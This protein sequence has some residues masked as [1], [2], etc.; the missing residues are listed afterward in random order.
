MSNQQHTHSA[1]AARAEAG[2]AADAAVQADPSA[3]RSR[4]YWRAALAGAPQGVDLPCQRPRRDRAAAAPQPIERIGLSVDA[5]LRAPLAALAERCGCDLHALLLAAWASLLGRLS[6]QDDVVVGAIDQSAHPL[7]LR[8]DLSGEPD[9][10]R[11]AAQV[12]ARLH[13]A[14]AHGE[15]S[16]QELLQAAHPAGDPAQALFNVALLL[17]HGPAPS[18]DAHDGERLDLALELFDDGARIGGALAYDAGLFDRAGAQRIGG[19]WLRLLAAMAAA[20]ERPLAA[21]PILAADERS[22]L[23]GDGN[24]RDYPR[25]LGVH[26]LFEAQA[27][28]TPAAAALVFGERTLSYADLE[29]RAEALAQALRAAGIGAGDR[30]AI[31]AARSV[32]LLVAILATLKSGAAYVP[33]DTAFPRERLVQIVE[34]SLPAL[35]LVDAEGAE[36]LGR[37]AE[38]AVA[39]LRTLALSA[40]GEAGELQ[41]PAAAAARDAGSDPALA[42]VLFTSGSTGR[43]KGVCVPHRAVV[44]FLQA[45]AAEPG[46]GSD[47]VLCAIT[48]ISFD[49]SVL[50]LLLPLS[51]GACVALADRRTAGDGAALAA[52]VERV[53]A[54]AMQATPATWRLLLDAGWTPPARMRLLC[55][56]EAW[57]MD[58]GERLLAGGARLWNVYGPTETTVWSMLERVVPGQ[59]RI[60]L[61]R[62]I[63]NTRIYLLDAYR[64]PVPA[65]V[66]GELYIGGDGVA[67]GYYGRT[68]L[69]A[70]R[71]LPDPHAQ[72]P[73]ARMYRTGDLARRRADGSLEFL[74]RNDFQVKIRGFR[75]ELGEIEARLS[76]CAGVREAVVLA[77][78]DAP[79]D[80]QLVAYY[81]SDEP[82]AVEAL[83]DALAAS[84]PGYMV[85]AAFVRMPVWPSTPNGKLDR[86]ALPAP[87][88]DA[89]A[90]RDYEPPQGATETALASIW[91]N[92][93]RIERVGRRD[94]F[95]ELGGHSLLAVQVLSRLRQAFAVEL[96]QQAL[97]DAPELAQLAAAVDAAERLESAAAIAPVARAEHMPLSLA[98]QRL[99]LLTQIDAASSAYHLYGALR[100]FG[101]VDRAALGRALRALAL[102]HEALRTRFVLVGERAMQRIDPDP[103]LTLEFA[104][105]RADAAGDER[106]DERERACA[107]AGARL[108]AAAFD[109]SRDLP[110]R[111]QLLHVHDEA[112][113]LQ[114][115]VH[116]IVADGWSMGVMYEDLGRLYAAELDGRPADLPA[117]PVQYADCAVW[118]RD[119]LSGERLD[120][121]VRFWRAAL[122]GAPPLLELPSDRSRP[123]RQDFAGACVPVRIEP[124]FAGQLKA[125]ARRHG[126]TLYMLLLSAWGLALGRLAHQDEV[127]IGSP[128]AGR[129]RVETEPLIGFFVNTLALRVDLRGAPSVAGLLERVR[130]HVLQ[131]QAHQDLPFDQVVEAVNP[132][133][134]PAHT[135]VYQAM[136]ALQNQPATQLRMPGAAVVEIVPE[137]TSVQC[138]LLLDLSEIEGA[139]VGRLDYASALFDPDT[140]A[141]FRDAWLRVLQAMLEEP[142]RSVDELSMIDDA[143]RQQ[144]LHLWN[145]TEREYPRDS[146]VHA[147]FQAQ[148]ARTPQAPALVEGDETLSYAELNR[149]ANRIAHRLIAAGVRP[150]DRVAVCMRRSAAMI[151]GL[152]G[153]LKAGAGYVPIDPGYPQ[154]RRAYLLADC[155]PSA[156]LSEAA[157]READWLAA[158]GVPVLAADGADDS[159]DPVDEHDPA[160]AVSARHLAYVIYTSGSTGEPKGVMVEHRN[161]LRLAVNNT[162]AVLGEGDCVAHCSNPS[163]DA[164]TWEI[165]GALLNGA[166]VLV[167]AADTV[168][169]PPSFNRA[170]LDGG[171]TALW[172]TVGLFNEYQQALAPA[173]AGLRHLL[174]G[175]DALD[176]RKV[177]QALAAPQ[178]PQRIVNGYGPTET[179]TFALT[180]DIVAVEPGARSIPIGRPIANSRAYLLDARLQP[181]PVGVAGELYLGGDGVARGYLNRPQLSAERF[182]ADPFAAAA[183]GE[184]AARMYKTGDLARWRSDGTVEF[185]GRNDFQVK[186]RGF[187]I[188]LGEIEARL[189]GCAGVAEAVVL[190]RADAGQAAKR[191]VAY[192][193]AGEGF[194]VAA[195]RAALASELPEYMLPSAFVR[196]D[197]W[198]LTANGKLDRRALPAPEH[199]AYARS[200]YAPP[201]GDAEQAAAAAWS[202]ALKLERVGRDDN[203]FE[204]GGH[205]LIAVALVQRLR[206]RGWRVDTAHLFAAAS[207]KDFAAGLRRDAADAQ[208]PP[209]RIPA[210]VQR[211][212]PQMLPLAT[213]TQAQIDTVVAAVGGAADIQ[214]IY[215]LAPLQEGILFHRMLAERG[216]LY[217]VAMLM[218]FADRAAVED[219]LAAMQQVVDRHDILRTGFVWH[220]LSAPLQVVRRHAR[221]EH[222]AFEFDPADGPVAEQLAAR[223]EPARFRFDLSRA[224]L[225]RLGYAF[226]PQSRQWLLCV[227]FH[228]L[229]MDHTSMEAVLREAGAILQGRA[230]ELPPPVPFREHI[231]RVGANADAQAQRAFFARMLGDIDQPT[232]PFGLNQSSDDLVRFDEC[233]RLLPAALSAQLR[234]RARELGVSATALLHLGWAMVLARATGQE[235]V[236]FGTVLFGRMNAG[237]GGDRALGLFINTL[238]IRIE[239]GDDG[240]AEAIRRTHQALGELLPHEHAPLA[241]AQRCSALPA[242]TPL[243]TSLFNYTYSFASAEAEAGLRMEPSA[244]AERTNYPL[245]VA[246]DD[247]G[248]DFEIGVQVLP[249]IGA[250]RVFD[251]LHAALAGIV[252]AL[253]Q[254]PATPVAAIEVM[255]AGE[256]RRILEDWN[257]SVRDFPLDTCAHTLFAAQAARSGAATALVFGEQRIGYADLNA[258]ANRIAHC[259]RR[260]G[261]GA[262]DLVALA[263]ERGIDMVA[264]ILGTLKAGAAYVPM[265]TD[266]PAER[267]A[268]MLED[269][270]PK[271]LLAHRSAQLPQPCAAPLALL[272]G[273]EAELAASPDSDPDPQDMHAARPAYV[274]YTSGTTGEPKGV[275][276]THRNLVNFVYWCGDAGLTAPGSSMTQFAPYTFDASAGEIF[277]ALLAGTCLHLLDDATIQ[278]PQKLQEYLSEHRVQFSAL[279]PAYLQQMDPARAPE[280]FRLLTAGSAPTPELVER[281][282]GRGDYLNGYGPTETTILSTATA[283]SADTRT[284]SIGRPVANT[285]VYLLDPRGRP[286]PVGAS[287]E[288]WI[289][290]EGVTPGYLNRPE[291]TAERYRPD[292]F[293]AAAGARMYRTGDLGRWLGDGTIEFLGRNDFQ[294]KIRGFRIEPGEIETRLCGFD[295]VREAVVLARADARGENR[296][297]AYYL[298]PAACDTAALRQHL[299]QALPEYMLPAAFVWMREWPLTGNGK[300]D[301]KAL[302]APDE[303]AFARRAYA[304]PEG[305]RE[306]ALAALWAELL[307]VGEI[308]RHDHFFELGGHSLL[309]MRLVS[310]I[311]DGFG[312]EL[313]LRTLFD[314]PV[315]HEL[316]QRLSDPQQARS[317]AIA[318]RPRDGEP[319]LAPAQQ[320]LWFLSQIEGAS[321]AYHMGGAV[322]LRGPLDPQALAWALQAVVERHE[323]L[324][325]RFVARDGR[326]SLRI[327]PQARIELGL[328]DLRGAADPQAQAQAAWTALFERG[329]DLAAD[330]PLR[331]EL[332]RVGEDEH[333]L[334]LAMHH[335]VSDGWSIGVML[336]ELGELYAARLAG[337]PDPLPPLPVQ[338]AD[339]AAWQRDWLE[340]GNAERLSGYWRDALAGAPSA[341]ELPGDRPRPPLQDFSGDSVPVRLDADLT[342]RLRAL[343]QR[344]GTTLYA[345][346]LASWAAL[347][348]RLSNQDEVVV[349]APMAGRGRG[350]IEPLI[351]FF[352]NTVALRVDLAA[353]ADVA[354]L[355]QQCKRTLVD[356]Q[357]HQDLPFDYVVEAVKPP[358]SAAHTPIFQTMLTLNERVE[359]RLRLPGVEAIPVETESR[360]AQFDLSLDLE[361][362]ERDV[363]GTLGYATALFDRSTVQRYAGYWLRLLQ[364]MAAD[365][366]RPLAQLPLADQAERER[367][368]QYGRGDEVE[369]GSAAYLH[370]RFEAQAAATPDAI[371]LICAGRTIA[372]GELNA[373]AN[374]I[375]HRLIA[376]GVGPDAT[377]AVC[378]DRGIDAIAALLGVLKAGGAYVPIDPQLPAERIGYYARDCAPAAVVAS[379]A[380]APLFDAVA[381]AN[382]VCPDRDALDAQPAHD[383]DP[384]ARGLRSA[385]LAYVI[386]TSGSTGQPKGVLIEHRSILARVEHAIG[387]YRLQPADR[388]LQF[389]ALGF[390]ASLLQIFSALGA[391]ASL[392]VR[393]PEPWSAEQ[394]VAEIAAHGI[395]VADLPPSYL[396]ALLLAGERGALERLRI[397]VIGGEATLCDTLRG[398]TAGFA[399][400][401]EYGPTEASVTATSLTLAAGEPVALAGQY[402]PIGRPVAGT[403]AYV[404]DRERRVAPLGAV[405]ELYIGGVGVARGYLGRDALT[406]E[407]FLADPFDGG[408]DARMYRSGDLVRWLPHGELEYLGRNDFQVKLRGFRIELGE[409]EAQMRAYP[410]VREAVAVAR[411]AADGQRSLV[412]YCLV[413]GELSTAGLRAHLAALLPDYMVPAGLVGLDRW[414][415]TS[416]GKLDRNAL[417]APERLACTREGYAPPQGAVERAI[418]AV[419]AQTLGLERVGRDDRFFD[420]GGHSLLM[421]SMIRR[422]AEQGIA[423]AVQDV[424]RFGSLRAIAARAADATADLGQWLRSRD[425]RHAEATVAGRRALWLAPAGE[426]E[427][428]ALKRV[429]SRMP[430]AALPQRIACADDPDAALAAARLAQAAAAP[431]DSGPLL[432]ELEDGLARGAAVLADAAV[433]ERLAFA[434]IHRE[435]LRWNGRD[436]LHVVPLAGWWSPQ[437]LRRAFARVVREQP[438]LRAAA[439]L[440]SAAFE[441][442]DPDAFAAADA[443]WLDLREVAAGD[444]DAH[445]ARIGERL[446]AAKAASRLSYAAALISHSD[447]E[448]LLALY[449]D[450]LIWD[451]QSFD[452]IEAAMLAA[453]TA[454]PAAAPAGYG[455]FLRAAADA[456][457]ADREP[458]ALD[459]LA[460]PFEPAAL[461]ADLRA[462][463]A[464][465]AGRRGQAQRAIAARFAL[466][467][468]V[469]PAQQAFAAFRRLASRVLGLE[470][471]GAVLTHHGRQL[472]ERSL[473]GE[474]GLFVDK[475]PLRVDA[476]AELDAAMRRVADLHREGLRYIDWQRS[477]DARLAGTLPDFADEVS[478]NY[479]ARIG[480]AWEANAAAV[481]AMLEKIRA[482][483]GIVCEF[484][485]GDDDLQMFFAFKGN[486][487]DEANVKALLSEMSGV[488]LDVGTD[489]PPAHEPQSPAP[490]SAPAAPVQAREAAIVVENLRKRYC[491]ADVVKGI[492]FSVPKG[493]CFGILGPNGAGKTSLLGMIEGIVPISS[494]RIQV[495]G[496]DVASQIRKIQPHFGVQLQYSHY[497]QFLTIRELL[498]FYSELRAAASGKRKVVP[499]PG[500]LER[501][502]LADKLK[503]KVEEL[504]GGQK[505]RLSIALALLDDPQIVFLDEPT[506]A[507]DPHSRRYTWEFI[508]ELKRDRNRTIVLTTHYME[509]AERLCDEIMIMNQGEIVGQGIPSLLIADLNAARQTRIKLAAHAPGEAIARAVCAR[510]PTVWDAF[511]DSL[512]ISSNEVAE[513]MGE[514]MAQAQAY[515][516]AIVDIHLERLSLEDVFLNK[517]GK[518]LK[519]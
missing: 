183:A 329:F 418:A 473:F 324:R 46:L 93:L 270:A 83:R 78:E 293:S 71:F 476:A 474:V 15:L 47:D 424:Y 332:L 158:A 372:Y 417:P 344:Q 191:L 399:I 308:G 494:G 493:S 56:G 510:Y 53:G 442:L 119:W 498:A 316:A 233:A 307:G 263:L 206:R 246:V 103:A 23:L 189:A 75:I 210:G 277:A 451:G 401:N 431:A 145:R 497:F 8:I 116:H 347:L 245:A 97:F 506:A 272:D 217:Q 454:T 269:C 207:L 232:M 151:V 447:G 73:D 495:M 274:I 393:G 349:G 284:I 379:H 373:R 27:R 67:L 387:A 86:R 10:A 154:A 352:V 180:H 426:D 505:Q 65:G 511:T 108:F 483:D 223:Y 255:P 449:G 123:P 289:G 187:R 436:A 239:V 12:R 412:G 90:R 413:D 405:G 360:L 96:G 84:L 452:A 504:S 340:R 338:Y 375:A 371:A 304:A 168:L 392:L 61:G 7:P 444:I 404:L 427:L 322:A 396:P 397:A 193:L 467:A 363:R 311:R 357:A 271:L 186:I 262:G 285:R 237:E 30:V 203:F 400:H 195:V 21:L 35:A 408:A 230:A 491:D 18:A 140:A 199:D 41:G 174:I 70:E 244:G 507:L 318:P 482:S 81:Q 513:A 188:E 117:L 319:A 348:G 211:I 216:D 466:A 328:A 213:L 475:I 132:P 259:L 419:W 443:V 286:V 80:K 226:D 88:G 499:P 403:R 178:R 170:L 184:P 39:Q 161:V 248:E 489:A 367:L 335:I 470:R 457:G 66:A 287:G 48:T 6:N 40:D 369:V 148:A 159:A 317:E 368:L 185:L 407:R 383:P 62:P 517:T 486:D 456:V 212:E 28:R 509:E 196:I 155:A 330:L 64:E 209:N 106:L 445:H 182:L 208:V 37:G 416:A 92:L 362:G 110:L 353:A 275:V 503:F 314:A 258:R 241:L 298:A 518:E 370:Q 464:A 306:R 253:E 472:G 382:V 282:A 57:Q 175:G 104:D 463:A 219:F 337:A 294:V 156:I 3:Q 361:E 222:D 450:H 296:L 112:F 236:V 273:L 85:P 201:Q 24:P 142:G 100:L 374:R 441:V 111:A 121:Q 438:M 455:E 52:F 22:G 176:P 346:L 356:A 462:T 487:G 130:R 113:E 433:V 2:A 334:H 190:A 280:G 36:L 414:P 283:L 172:L 496:M 516:A 14:A 136:L 63:D 384:A 502:D 350:E 238:P 194:D 295:G 385:H 354:A 342:E 485:A 89:Y 471:F 240:I 389:T 45:M 227:A 429:L 99:W 126:A 51:V 254:D 366:R 261:V 378:L 256:R 9:A 179:T 391:G 333:R 220:G 163:F 339:F 300:I 325:T 377:V 310:R 267:I 127:V 336:H 218:R 390:D 153:I 120:A 13:A 197:A 166:R 428:Q 409:I 131:A 152:L 459:R 44:N 268:F 395:S 202:E 251:Y 321:A 394:T 508:E 380:L 124:A 326:P 177:A 114:L 235:R 386:Y 365:E 115:V 243:F 279:P 33:L 406:A 55:G 341:L 469:A 157:L 32:G 501:L 149:R 305:E 165:W 31:C 415:L 490:A 479:Q 303:Q 231:W 477:G 437:E 425:W 290:G 167:I 461:A 411:D 68:E 355:L 297:L 500:L 519:P 43:P 446:R 323:A 139:V 410:G 59:A 107:E 265:A 94:H 315:L 144:V 276:V 87:D 224:P 327:D 105:L 278:S 198:P 5:G 229:A 95:F 320:R 478:F 343:S 432:R 288:I 215:P 147:V 60:G 20:P 129:Q 351:G 146:S 488:L 77:R 234:R 448:H 481:G 398:K 91:Q 468:E 17:R 169:D 26:Q 515:G 345:T 42:Y 422:L 76:A 421:L 11:L 281:W 242:S 301:R 480:S 128:V 435:L 252:Q 160:P 204:L 50:E 313:P 264:A 205:S 247:R 484:F 125:L 512:V 141:R 181:V 291:L 16:A 388:C 49:I 101:T 171:A 492:S 249:Q 173:F 359:S 72:R 34:D 1:G 465:L 200:E 135:P 376:L 250:E 54:T 102:R 138:D 134:N 82:Q 514:A 143:Q 453:L 439:D 69:T 118:Q 29:R 19:Y 214:D 221:L 299:S 79:G 192:C 162:F 109:L 423:V 430:A 257:D 402:L 133:R 292:P 266:A 150:D 331:A 312:V 122:A 225:L 309:A 98:Q 228:H 38:A 420:L 25:E 137:T 58:L 364:A 260:R 440:G 74:G 381:G 302:P 164:S 358:R 4:E 458:A 434:A 460:A